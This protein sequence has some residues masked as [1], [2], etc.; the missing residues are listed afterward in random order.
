MV[1]LDGSLMFQRNWGLELQPGPVWRCKSS[2]EKE[3]TRFHHTPNE[4][5]VDGRKGSSVRNLVVLH[6]TSIGMSGP[7]IEVEPHPER[8]K[9]K[10][11][12]AQRSCVSLLP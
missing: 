8:W 5:S 3:F 10:R 6:S 1:K 11:G 7:D 4:A 12:T 2:C 9:R